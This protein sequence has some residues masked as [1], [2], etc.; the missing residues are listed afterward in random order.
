MPEPIFMNLGMYI[1]A[2]EPIPTAYFINPSH[3]SMCLYVN[4]P[5]VARKRLGEN[6]TAVTNI[7]ITIEEFLDASYQSKIGG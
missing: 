7:H 4:L 5:I 2:P 6:F 1:I 3:L